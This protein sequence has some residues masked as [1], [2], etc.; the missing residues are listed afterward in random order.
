MEHK[1]YTKTGDRGETSLLGGKRVP[2]YHIRVEAYGTIDELKSYLALL[3]NYEKAHT[4]NDKIAL[5]QEKLF[6][7]E[8]L[9]ACEDD[10]MRKNLP[11]IHKED[12][13]FLEFE[14]DDMNKLLPEL[15]HFIIPGG[16]IYSAHAHVARCICR[17]AER[18][19]IQLSKRETIETLIITYLNRLSDYL[20]VLARFFCID[21]ENCK[22]NIWKTKP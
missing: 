16:N 20:F 7:V 21:I 3:I 12:I 2:K 1:I 4:V 10:E 13:N 5:I 22:E 17:R 8:A 14:I 9:V 6:R 18:I 15:Q 19:V 11:Q